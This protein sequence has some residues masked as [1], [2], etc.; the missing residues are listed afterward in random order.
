MHRIGVIAIPPVTAFDFAIPELVFA[1][2]SAAPGVRRHR[3][4][5]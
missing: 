5:R 3:L 2:R 4:H 1:T